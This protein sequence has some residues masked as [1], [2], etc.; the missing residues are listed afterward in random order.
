MEFLPRLS[1]EVKG[2]AYFFFR[3][4]SCI[5]IARWSRDMPQVQLR[6]LDMV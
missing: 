6:W 1:I 2:T 5:A 4:S 3:C